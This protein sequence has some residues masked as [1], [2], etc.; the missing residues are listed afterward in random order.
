MVAGEKSEEAIPSGEIG[1]CTDPGGGK[2]LD[3]GTVIGRNST[4]RNDDSRRR[5]WT[6]KEKSRPKW[7]G[8]FI[9]FLKKVGTT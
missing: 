1:M 7:L 2:N 5:L 3:V 4:D 8:V 6:D 9:W